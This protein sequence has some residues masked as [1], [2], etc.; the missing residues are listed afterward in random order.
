MQEENNRPPTSSR[1]SLLS[2]EPA[3]ETG[4]NGILDGLE[5]RPPAAAAARKVA[6]SRKYL[7]VGLGAALLVLLA[8]G[9][10]TWS[11]MRPGPQLTLPPQA[12]AQAA[13]APATVPA[14]APAPAVSAPTAAP[15]E[16]A[17]AAPAAAA[18]I[19]EDTAAV[20]PPAENAR[21]L[22]EMLNETPPAKP[23]DELT[24]ALE[25]PHAAQHKLAE[26]KV[27]DHKKA[28]KP[29]KKTVQVAKKAETKKAPAQPDS[30]VALLAA[31]VA[32]VQA[33]RPTAPS[34][35]AYQLKQCSRMNEAG[36]AQCRQHLCST[37]AR[38]EP[39]C[40]Q[41]VAV[42]TASES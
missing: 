33:G 7:P 16:P 10:W 32:H 36:A 40:K 35:P 11:E 23:R 31:L 22:K 3:A 2:K 39:E 27:A 38:N 30:D 24:A 5:R 41:P 25:R 13:A 17:P 21:S 8:A 34:T 18:S 26:K 1:P 4:R 12:Q 29:A 15:A 20:S 28:D 14:T 37:T 9:A 6:S 19:V 42:K